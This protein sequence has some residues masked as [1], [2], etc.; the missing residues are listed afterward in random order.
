MSNE[1]GGGEQLAFSL[2][3]IEICES[4]RQPTLSRFFIIS[5]KG[6]LLG[7][8]LLAAR[9]GGM[10]LVLSWDILERSGMN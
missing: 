6:Y 3:G 7:K 4:G 10:P 9:T 1:C 2:F 5:R 8:I